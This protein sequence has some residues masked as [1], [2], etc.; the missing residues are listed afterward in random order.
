MNKILIIIAAIIFVQQGFSQ[1]SADTRLT[2]NPSLSTTSFA[3]TRCIASSGMLTAA[4]WQ[5]LRD[6]N[7]EIY[8]KRSTDGGVTWGS[9]TRLTNDTSSSVHPSIEISG[10][11]IH[12]SW[13]DSRNG[14][15]E[16]YYKRSTN[17]GITW[18]ADT[19]MTNN[20]AQSEKPSIAAMNNTVL[21]T[22][23]DYRDGNKEIYLLASTNGGSS[24]SAE[25]RLTN[26]TAIS[27]YPDIEITATTWHLAWREFR[28]GAPQVFYKNSTN[29]GVTWS[30]DTKIVNTGL[31]AENISLAAVGSAVHVC[32]ADLRNSDYEIY[33]KRSTDNGVSW[34]A[35]QRITNSSG[36]SA[37]P[38]ISASG[39]YVHIVWEDERD[40]STNIYYKFSTN[41][42]DTWGADYQLVNSSVYAKQPSIFISGQT[43][44]VVWEDNRDGNSEI[45]YKRNPLGN[46]VAVNNISTETPNKFSLSQNYPNPFNPVTSIEFS[47]TESAATSIIIYDALGREVETLV[48]ENL[49]AGVYKTE[50]NASNYN[51]GVYFYKLVSGN[52]TETK[53]MLM[54]K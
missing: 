3:N 20:S 15:E 23:N 44:H 35:D 26:N 50:W 16:I 27:D 43:V 31:D 32:W 24:W 47:I 11:V 52:N 41:F 36:S 5:E 8:I 46:L 45:Y 54:V 34:G 17:A 19:R 12:V 39:V 13:C 7:E 14:N 38:N 2:N 4:V 29:A 28:T 30:A 1:W 49:S 37:L 6:G 25:T 53:R 48:N 33:Y 10:A 21:I 18:S 51:S 40:T 42:G 9:D 22:W